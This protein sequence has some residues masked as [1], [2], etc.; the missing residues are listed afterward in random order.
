MNIRNQDIKRREPISD[1][2]VKKSLQKE[3]HRPVHTYS[4]LCR[5]PQTDQM[6]AAVQSHW[7]SV[8]SLVTWGEAGVGLIVIRE[9]L[10][11]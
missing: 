3:P 5:D 11:L 7:F 6:G 4:I 9:M 2:L 8:D 10:N 1:N